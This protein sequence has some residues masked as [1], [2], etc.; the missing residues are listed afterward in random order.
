MKT[1]RSVFLKSLC[2]VSYRSLSLWPLSLSLVL[3]ALWTKFCA[4]SKKDFF[5]DDIAI[6]IV[7][8]SYNVKN[9]KGKLCASLI[10]GDEKRIN[11]CDLWP[12]HISIFS[13]NINISG[14]FQGTALFN[15]NPSIANMHYLKVWTH[16]WKHHYCV[17]VP[18]LLFSSEWQW[19]GREG[20]PLSWG[21]Q[22][23]IS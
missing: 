4:C 5:K 19:V 21:F 20:Q 16:S 9:V 22:A 2:P 15:L 3:H 1:T 18:P 13:E 23:T 11:H 14:H 8:F 6:N 12:W 7:Q 10:S 17:C